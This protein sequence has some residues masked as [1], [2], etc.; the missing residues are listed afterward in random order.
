[1]K[2]AS[3]LPEALLQVSEEKRQWPRTSQRDLVSQLRWSWC[4]L[5][6][7]LEE[8]AEEEFRLRAKAVNRALIPN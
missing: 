5:W 4:S 6:K 8:A 3:V 2:Q 1:M 7:E